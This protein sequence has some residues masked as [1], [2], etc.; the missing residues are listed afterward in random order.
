MGL[1]IQQDLAGMLGQKTGWRGCGGVA[2]AGLSSGVARAG[3]S[4]GA[5]VC[6]AA[7]ETGQPRAEVAQLQPD[8]CIFRTIKFVNTCC[9][10]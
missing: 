9:I 7:V 1:G 8:Q 6:K 2:R 4:G 10:V 3:L 5:V